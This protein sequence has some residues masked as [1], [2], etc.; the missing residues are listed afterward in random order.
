MA[1]SE[2]GYDKWGIHILVSYR[3]TD[4]LQILTATTQ[5]GGVGHLINLAA[6]DADILQERSLAT[7]TYLM[8][9][10]VMAR[11]PFSLVDEINQGMDQKAE[12][13]VHNQ[14]VETTCGADTGQYFLITPKLLTNLHYHPRMK[15]LVVNSGPHRESPPTPSRLGLTSGSSA[16]YQEEGPAVGRA[17]VVFEAVQSE[18]SGHRAVVQQ[19]RY[20]SSQHVNLPR[21]QPHPSLCPYNAYCPPPLCD[22]HGGDV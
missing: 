12:R 7:V 18:P 6:V 5:S 4:P 13:A 15:V 22:M 14:L 19:V 8:S 2:E 17:V 9:L 20:L 11:T 3:D 16:R 1:R 21:I 10:S